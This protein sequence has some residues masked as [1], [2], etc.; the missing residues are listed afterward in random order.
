MY[1]SEKG[2]CFRPRRNGF[3]PELRMCAADTYRVTNR[4][5]RGRGDRI[6]IFRDDLR[7]VIYIRDVLYPLFGGGPP[8]EVGIFDS[9]SEIFVL[10][11]NRFFLKP[12]CCL[13]CSKTKRHDTIIHAR[14]E[15]MRYGFWPRF[16]H[17]YRFVYRDLNRINVKIY[18]KNIKKYYI[19]F[20]TCKYFKCLLDESKKKVN[21]ALICYFITYDKSF[22][23]I[24]KI[25]SNVQSVTAIHWLTH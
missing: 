12:F 8:M 20:V 13:R 25:L 7:P 10:R 1:V 9:L 6:E 15:L 19:M 11:K 16:E 17:V 4:S 23:W 5:A 2:K 14:N 21:T 3:L 24:N 18:A 22:Y